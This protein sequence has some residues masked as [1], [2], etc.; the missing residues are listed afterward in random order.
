MPC[1]TL[2]ALVVVVVLMGLGSGPALSAGDLDCSDFSTQAQAQKHLLPGDPHGLD[3]DGDG[4]ACESLPCPCAGAGGR[5]GKPGADGDRGCS[6]P[7]RPVRITFSRERYP[8]IIKH[9]KI[10]WKRG[11]P[12]KLVIWR[13]GA[14][15]RRDRLLEGIPTKPGYDRDE[16]PAAV[17]R[18]KVQASVRY[19]PSGENRSAGASLGSQISGYCNGVRVRY[20]FVR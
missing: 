11:Y 19:V 16:A 9:I 5:P 14:D 1:A 4:R 10:S 3:A 13:P 2:L 18:K 8:N 12:K 7:D 15:R 6:R 17:L 20:R